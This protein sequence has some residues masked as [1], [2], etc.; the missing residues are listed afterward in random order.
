MPKFEIYATHH[1]FLS[2]Q[3]EAETKEEALSIVSDYPISD[4]TRD[5]DE[6]EIHL[7]NVEII[8]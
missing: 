6:L 7:D 8:N 4:W 1:I 3:V 5:E 2:T